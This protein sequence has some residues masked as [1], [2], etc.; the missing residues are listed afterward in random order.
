MESE[1]TNLPHNLRVLKPHV[2]IVSE[3][4]AISAA[5][6]RF[7][8]KK[9]SRYEDV[10]YVISIII[11]FL[12][13]ILI[14]YKS[15]EYYIYNTPQYYYFKYYDYLN[16][17]LSGV[18]DEDEIN[19]YSQLYKLTRLKGRTEKIERICA[20]GHH[21]GGDR[22]WD[23]LYPFYA[24]YFFVGNVTFPEKIYFNFTS[25]RMTDVWDL[26]NYDKIKFS[27]L[28]GHFYRGEAI[29]I[30]EFVYF[31]QEGASYTT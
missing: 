15:I 20:D 16:L 18:V 10:K 21:V 26:S 22:P 11:I 29:S 4:S 7:S 30:E 19:S 9:L 31:I 6:T 1:K 28:G 8:L 25:D 12:S 17:S 24:T 2:K 13:I 14:F 27:R 3:K 23:G 5:I